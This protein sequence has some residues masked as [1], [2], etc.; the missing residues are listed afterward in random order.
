MCTVSNLEIT[1]CY[2]EI[3]P[4]IPYVMM[5][6]SNG[7]IFHVTGHLCGEFTGHRWIALT[8][9]SDADLWCFLWSA[10]EI[11]DWVNNREAGDLK[12]YRAHYDITVMSTDVLAPKCARSSNGLSTGYKFRLITFLSPYPIQN[13]WYLE[14]SQSIG[15]YNHGI[16]GTP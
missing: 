6:S 8:K 13:K 10:S 12:C 3:A 14:K 9:A 4:Y 15:E 2:M 7:N 1:D 11:N 16:T 5:T